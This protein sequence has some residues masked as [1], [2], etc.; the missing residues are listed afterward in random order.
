VT[1]D[2]ISRASAINDLVDIGPVGFGPGDVYVF[3]DRLFL[4]SAPGDQ[5]GRSDGRCILIDPATFRFDCSGTISLPDGDIMLAGTFTLIEG[6]TSV[7]AIV[8]GTE[9]YRRVRGQGS[10]ELGP[11][12]GPHD[13][14]LELV[15]NP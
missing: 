7:G 13:V 4:T 10:V 14:T 11:F 12:E 2:L 15:L 9:A 8:G 1:I 5:I 3:S 6:T